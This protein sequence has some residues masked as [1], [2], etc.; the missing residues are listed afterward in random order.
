MAPWRNIYLY[1]VDHD[2]FNLPFAWKANYILG[3]IEAPVTKI[4]DF[5]HQYFGASF[6]SK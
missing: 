4:R 1:A 6:T 5:L 3:M 2:S